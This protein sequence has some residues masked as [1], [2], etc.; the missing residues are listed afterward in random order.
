MKTF[1]K[2]A[3]GAFVLVSTALTVSAPAQAKV[4]IG[5]GI[6]LGGPG[7]YAPYPPAYPVGPYP[8]PCYYEA[9]N[10]PNPYCGYPVYSG[11]V[12][13]GGAWYNGPIRY[14][15]VRGERQYWISG[16][17]H[18]ATTRRGHR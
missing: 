17:W 16:G 3:F 9:A 13:F 8:D 10:G 6:D 12:F 15:D 18:A 1:A 5:V 11:P 7:P 2:I 14:R 4:N